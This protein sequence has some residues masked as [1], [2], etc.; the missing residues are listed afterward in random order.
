M[1]LKPSNELLR[2]KIASD[3][4]DEPTAGNVPTRVERLADELDDF[5][6]ALREMMDAYERRVR[7]D[8]TTPQQLQGQPWRCREFIVAEELLKGRR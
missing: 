5:R 8:C 4:D 6:V 1:D 2:R 7:S 3:P